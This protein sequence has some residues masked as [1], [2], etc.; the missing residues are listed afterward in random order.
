[1]TGKISIIIPGEARG[2]QRP[3]ATRQ[4]RIY[5]PSETRNQEAFIKYLAAQAMEG[6]PPLDG[7]LHLVMNI[8]VAVPKSFSKRKRAAALNSE[9]FPTTKPDLDNTLKLCADSFNGV[10]W[11]DDKQIVS[12]FISKD[13]G[14]EARTVLIVSPV[15]SLRGIRLE[16]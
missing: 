1:M 5:T 11:G 8:T 9:I 16:D 12:A 13:Y 3:R 2:K 7:P 10:V 4:G 15:P 14:E 6:K